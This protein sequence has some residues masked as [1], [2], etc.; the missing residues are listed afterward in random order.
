[1]A[2]K[3]D[4]LTSPQPMPCSPDFVCVH[5]CRYISPPDK[6]PHV[7]SGTSHGETASPRISDGYQLW[8]EACQVRHL[9]PLPH[10]SQVP[11][12]SILGSFAVSLQPVML[13]SPHKPKGQPA[14]WCCVHV[15]P[16][17]STLRIRF[18]AAC[19]Y[20]PSMMRHGVDKALQLDPP[21]LQPQWESRSHSAE[22]HNAKLQA[23]NG[24]IRSLGLH[25]NCLL[26][27]SR[28]F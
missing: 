20:P 10:E 3:R 13:A 8:A 25:L 11:P 18:T 9:G 6:S 21:L 2:C 19:L 27:S 5:S 17:C 24:S 7:L 22:L 28:D 1:M 14:M 23:S 15:H 12:S 16:V 26:G 4:A